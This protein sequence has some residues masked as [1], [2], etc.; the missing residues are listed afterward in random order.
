MYDEKNW[1]QSKTIWGAIAV[2]ISSISQMAGVSLD[3]GQLTEATMSLVSL[4]G[5]VVAYV[6]RVKATHLIK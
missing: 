1:Y 6:G 5:G 4:V 2:I 3:A